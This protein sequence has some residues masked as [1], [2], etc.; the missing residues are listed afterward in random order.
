MG[1]NTIQT[2]V[3]WNYHQP[4]SPSETIRM[5]VL[6]DFVALAGSMDL[7][8][9]VR[10]GPYVCAEYFY[11]G[12]PLWMRSVGASCFRCSDPQWKHFMLQWLT[13]VAKTLRPLFASNGGPIIMVQVEN[14]YN[15]DDQAYLDWAVEAANNVTQGEVLWNL[16][17]SL[18]ARWKR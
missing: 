17:V 13:T 11:G 2:Y 9:T 10:I 18:C 4:R 7:H 1:L 6:T 5:D 16:C 15:G 8:V 14:E 3:F 12:L